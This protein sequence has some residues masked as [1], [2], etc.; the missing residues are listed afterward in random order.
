MEH[1]I[2]ATD[3]STIDWARA[4]A[5]VGKVIA[6]LSGLTAST[7]V[8]LG[9]RLGLFQA[10]AGAGDTTSEELAART[11]LSERYL[12]EWLGGMTAARYLDYDPATSRFRFPAEH[13]L[14]LAQEGGRMFLCGFHELLFDAASSALDRL[15]D[16]FRNGGGV[17]QSAYG[18]RFWKG[19]ERFTGGIYESRLVQELLPTLPEVVAALE[20]GVRVADV[21][22]GR[23]RALLKLARSYPRSR[24]VG[25]DF[26]ASSI[27]TATAN[28]SA[29]GIEDRV[30]FEVCDVTQGLPEEYDVITT[31]A[32]IHDAADPLAILRAIRRSL[33]PGGIYV[34]VDDN[35]SERLEENIGPISTVQYGASLLYCMTTSLAVG[36]AGL[37]TLGCH[38]PKLRGLCLEAGFSSVRHAPLDDPMMKIYEIRP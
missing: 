28:A 21:G 29:A 22:C 12:R 25:Y 1:E 8:V 2:A 3:E 4:E 17:P 37:G 23:G 35:C 6:D 13:A 9:D 33:K 18:E 30:R 11:G 36:G 31:F 10:L 20:R 26:F 7:M 5:F 27:E 15:V 24:Y 34:C 16:A 19:L 32:V 14:V 38:E